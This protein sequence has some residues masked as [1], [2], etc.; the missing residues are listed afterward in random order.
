[1]VETRLAC[2]RASSTV[3]SVGDRQ[4]DSGSAPSCRFRD[5]PEV[6]L[7]KEPEMDQPKARPGKRCKKPRS[8]GD[9]HLADE[10]KAGKVSTFSP[11][12]ITFFQLSG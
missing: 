6:E 7:A 3:E 11:F 9:P 4:G 5:D 12:F 1:M 8:T 10:I 2:K